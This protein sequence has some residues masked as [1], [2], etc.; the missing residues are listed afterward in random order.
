MRVLFIVLLTLLCSAVRA[1][2]ALA[3]NNSSY[4]SNT[5][6]VCMENA[7]RLLDE[8]LTLMQKN[9]YR[10]EYINWDTL[11]IAAKNKLQSRQNC[12]DAY[13][14][15]NWCF[16]EMR[17]K[18]SFI[19]PT[20]TAATYNSD[21]SQI[22]VTPPLSKLV[23][24]IYGEWISDSIAYITIPWVS[25]AND[26]ICTQ[27]ADSIQHLIASLDTRSVTKWIIDLRNNRGGNCWPML[28]GVGPLLGEGICGYFI[29]NE[30]KVSISYKNG[31]A[32]QGKTVRC[33]TSSEPYQLK[34]QRPTIIVLTNNTTSS[35]GEI[36][37][38]AFKGKE[39]VYFYGHPTAGFTTANATYSLSDKSM[40]VLTVC[41]EA[42][43]TGKI[44]NGRIFPDV[45]VST[46][47]DK[48]SIKEAAVQWLLNY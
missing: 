31:M 32:M 8:A 26:I 7:N 45:V 11:R 4:P 36:I 16:E 30:E 24:T 37:A 38:L 12:T 25:T 5:H 9:Y 13:E 1:Q 21:L 27:I 15:I 28:A 40:L 10:K 46:V 18:H 42:D 20:L 3:S 41:K 39:Q 47:S 2:T 35:S 6:S 33:K 14:T 34:S 29:R 19:M 44:Y 23:G 22:S 43:R 48:D 17:E